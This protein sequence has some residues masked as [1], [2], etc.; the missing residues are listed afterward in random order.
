[1]HAEMALEVQRDRGPLRHPE[2]DVIESLRLHD[3]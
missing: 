3:P 2:G 1:V